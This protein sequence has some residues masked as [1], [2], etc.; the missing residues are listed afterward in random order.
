M[1]RLI[2]V[3]IILV[4]V[5]ILWIFLTNVAICDVQTSDVHT[6][7]MV[8]FE[9]E[10]DEIA[11]D[12][13]RQVSS[14]SVANLTGG[15][16]SKKVN[17]LQ[18]CLLYAGQQSIWEH[19]SGSI[20]DCFEQYRDNWSASEIEDFASSPAT[21]DDTKLNRKVQSLQAREWDATIANNR[22]LLVLFYLPCMDTPVL[23]LLTCRVWS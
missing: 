23:S 2:S 6:G 5:S 8:A 17:N 22:L 12:T 9:M 1:Q 10:H 18:T 14:E 20:R 4:W 19:I 15:Y 13:D 7:E 3:K 21:K 11:I 16:S